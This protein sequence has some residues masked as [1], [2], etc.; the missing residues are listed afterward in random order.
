MYV[1]GSLFSGAGLG[2]LAVDL[3]GLEH[4]WFCEIDPFARRILAL[5]W[6]GVPIL[7]DVRH[8]RAGSVRPVDVLIGGFP[9]QDVSSAGLGRGIVEGTRSGLWFE[10]LRIIRELRPRFAVLENVKALL[11]RGMDTV[12]GGLAE[13]GY[14]AEWDVLPAAAFGAPHLRERVV[15]VAY[16][17]GDRFGKPGS[18]FAGQGNLGQLHQPPGQVDWNGLRLEGPRA[19]AAVQAYR[20]PL[21]CRVDDGNAG[22][23]DRLRCL[24]NGIVPDILLPVLRII[25]QA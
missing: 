16:P 18:V 25:G 9:C 5:R 2:D 3:A 12:L 15:I 19:Q 11:G 6:P 21:L 7:E 13:S 22:G 20:G 1:V 23:L 10:Y 14:D 4:G 17:Q 8:V 24:G